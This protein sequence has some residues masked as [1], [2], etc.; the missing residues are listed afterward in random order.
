M[1][2]AADYIRTRSQSWVF[3]GHVIKTRE[4]LLINRDLERRVP[5]RIRPASRAVRS[6]QACRPYSS[7]CCAVGR[8]TGVISLQNREREDAFSESDVRVMSTLASSLSVALENARL[9][10]ETKRLLGETDRRAAELAIVNEVQRGLAAQLDPQAMYELV[11]ERASDVFDTHVVDI[12]VFDHA[13]G[14]HAV[15]VSPSSAASA[16]RRTSA[17]SWASA[18]TC[19]RRAQPLLIAE[20][21][22]E[23]ATRVS[24]RA[25]RSR[26]SRRSPR[27]SRRCWWA[28]RSL[29][30]SRSRTWTASTPSMSA[31]SRCSPPLR[32]A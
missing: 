3:G 27:S 15:A 7:P 23:R 32:P 20:Q 21:L 17:R 12:T 14:D 24:G 22:R 10:D 31:T 19:S 16:S 18:S 1:S 25:P 30:S 2:R 28:T 9:F 6:C 4:P 13:H 26:A 29:A 8:S 11:G 5:E